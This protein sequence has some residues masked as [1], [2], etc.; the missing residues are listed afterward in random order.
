M[1]R[2]YGELKEAGY[3]YYDRQQD[4]GVFSTISLPV[5]LPGGAV[6]MRQR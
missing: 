6:S 5:L 3:V 2:V 1:R 4:N